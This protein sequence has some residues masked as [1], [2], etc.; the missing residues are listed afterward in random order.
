ML[1]GQAAVT[2]IWGVVEIVQVTGPVLLL[3]TTPQMLRPV[4]IKVSITE[5]LVGAK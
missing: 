4:A 2:I 5:Q 1:A 3:A